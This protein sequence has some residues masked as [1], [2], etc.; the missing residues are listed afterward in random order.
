[1]KL[2]LTLFALA[3]AVA[4]ASAQTCPNGNC[5]NV[6]Y[7]AFT[8]PLGVGYGGYRG[9]ALTGQ[10]CATCPAG[11]CPNCSV[12]GCPNGRCAVPTVA[13]SGP[14]VSWTDPTGTVWSG[15]AEALEVVKARFAGQPAV[16]PLTNSQVAPAVV[17]VPATP[18]NPP[19]YRLLP[20]TVGERIGNATEALDLVNAQRKANG[21]PPYQRDEGLTKAAAAAAEYRAAHGIAVHTANDFAFLPAGARA[22]AA[23]CA[24]WRTGFGACAV[25]DTAY[26]VAGAAFCVGADGLRYCHVFY[27]R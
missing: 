8:P 10:P 20:E 13:P 5:P 9:P 11:A 27:R 14:K 21:L 25:F 17:P 16:K 2:A 22:D 4:G 18:V 23:G 24:A 1:M 6:R 15:S 12:G 3:L 7:A 19:V 26:R